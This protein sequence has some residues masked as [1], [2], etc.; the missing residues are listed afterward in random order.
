MGEFVAKVLY[1]SQNYGL[2][3]PES[4][5]DYKWIEVP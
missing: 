3:T 5:R 4:D 1:G 2:D